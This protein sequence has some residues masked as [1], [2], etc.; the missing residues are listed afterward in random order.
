MSV[1]HETKSI[2]LN[3]LVLWEGNVRKTAAD[4]G[5]DELAASIEAHGLLNPLTVGGHFR[6]KHHVIAGGR[7][8]RALNALAQKGKLPKDWAVPCVVALDADHTEL[9]LAENVVRVAMHPADQF[10]AWKALA[11]QGQDTDRIAARFGVAESTV[12]K[13]LALARVSPALFALYREGEITLEALQAFTLTD[14]HARQDAVW[15]GLAEWQRHD[16]RSIRQALTEGDVPSSDRRVQFVGLDAYEAAGG[17][18]RRDLFEDR[19][20]V[21]DPSL[22]DRL[23]ME[24]LQALAGEVKGEGWAWTEARLSFSWDERMAFDEAEPDEG[25]EDE[26]SWPD[27]VKAV[28]GAI[29]YLGYHGAEIER[30]LIRIEDR[31]ADEDSFEADADATDEAEAGDMEA[32][33]KAPALP[34]SLIED[35]TAQRTAALRIELARRPD[36]ALAAIVHTVALSAF[37]RSTARGLKGGMTIRSLERSIK[38]HDEAPAVLALETERARV[39]D[40]LPGDPADL[41]GWCLTAA[42]DELLDVLAVA[43]AYGVDAVAT[44][45]EPN[46]SGVAFGD[47]LAGAVGLDMAAWYAAT[48][49]G[50]F[51]RVP[52]ALILSDLEAAKG[53]PA[54][55]GWAKLKKSELAVLAERET[56]SS[57]WL[58]APLR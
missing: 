52:K 26:P 11:D 45:T 55:P 50:Y 51:S 14:D 3:R 25:D 43:A 13:R 20:Y 57:G 24:K 38:G 53:V 58:P 5:I 32:G 46:R 47:A 37:Y 6:K 33:G 56:A 29:V 41:W 18:V 28:A 23:A 42:Q 15:E 40:R 49:E 12:R 31:T 8:L 36:V 9:S 44:K 30:G 27:G 16:A 2:P 1:T 39:C 17:P 48:A 7:R 34:A 54:A 19:G 35:L 4:T 21:Q 10:E 22:L